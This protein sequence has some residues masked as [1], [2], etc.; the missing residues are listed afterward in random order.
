MDNKYIFVPHLDA[1]MF[2]KGI[3]YFWCKYSF[4]KEKR[5]K[6]IFNV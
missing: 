1:N 2:W 3:L 6:R 5:K 4:I